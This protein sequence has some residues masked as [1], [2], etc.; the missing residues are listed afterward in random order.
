MREEELHGTQACGDGP[1]KFPNWRKVYEG[2]LTTGFI[3][4]LLGRGNNYRHIP[5]QLGYL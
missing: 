3:D 5:D 4:F 2:P 1:I